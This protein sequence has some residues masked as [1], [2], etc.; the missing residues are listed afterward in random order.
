MLRRQATVNKFSDSAIVAMRITSSIAQVR[1]VAYSSRQEEHGS[2]VAQ[3]THIDAV[4]C[5][6]VSWQRRA[7]SNKNWMRVAKAM[8][9]TSAMPPIA[10][11][12]TSA[13][14]CNTRL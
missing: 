4:T 11:S 13:A 5:R 2:S 7:T 10:M 8:L 6:C 9:H 14:F 3:V 12:F 1:D